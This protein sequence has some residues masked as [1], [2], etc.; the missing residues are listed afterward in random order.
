MKF[1][2]DA[3]VCLFDLDAALV[4]CTIM[5]FDNIFDGAVCYQEGLF[6]NYVDKIWWS[7]NAYF[8]QGTMQVVKKGQ[9]YIHIVIE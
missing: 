8:C 7:K 5:H 6:K 9:N 3:V 4:N 1:S 2:S